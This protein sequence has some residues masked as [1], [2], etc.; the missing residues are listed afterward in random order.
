MLLFQ[1]QICKSNLFKAFLG[2]CWLPA[3]G[4]VSPCQYM[5]IRRGAS[6]ELNPQV[7]FSGLCV[8]H[9]P[10]PHSMTASLRG[11]MQFAC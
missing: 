4:T 3:G 2:C 7:I 5:M 8:P 6:C 9:Q 1:H 11:H 10:A